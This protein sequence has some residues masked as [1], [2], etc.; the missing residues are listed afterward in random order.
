MTISDGRDREGRARARRGQEHAGEGRPCEDRDALDPARD[1]I[2]CGQLVGSPR[3]CRRQGRL[4]GPEGRV[5]HRGR[6]RER[7]DDE[8]IRVCEHGD[9]RGSD[10]DDAADVREQE[11]PFARV[12]VAEHSGERRDERGRNEAGEE[13]E[14]DGLLAAD[15]VGV[16]RDGDEERV[17]ADDRA[18]PRELEPAQIRV[19]PDGRKGGDG[20]SEAPGDS[21]HGGSISSRLAE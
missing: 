14:S 20:V 18:R 12:A 4:R 15:S 6:D 21:A 8:G 17:V 3:E 11:N 5:R 9:G 1:G 10:E 13:E 19:S 16:D 7:V 2:R